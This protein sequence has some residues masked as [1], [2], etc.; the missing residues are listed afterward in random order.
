MT[1]LKENIDTTIAKI[2]ECMAHDPKRAE[3][4]LRDVKQWSGQ[5]EQEA[6]AR[7][8]AT[9][10]ATLTNPTVDMQAAGMEASALGRPDAGDPEYVLS[11]WRAMLKAARQ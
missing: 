6:Y 2:M 1:Y 11:I 9:L 7:G 10:A 4:L 8:R 3:R 5:L